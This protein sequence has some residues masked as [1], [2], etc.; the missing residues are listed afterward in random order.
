MIKHYGRREFLQQ[1][2]GFGACLLLASN[3]IYLY[4]CEDRK[5]QISIEAVNFIGDPKFKK[6]ILLGMDGLDPRVLNHLM[7]TGKLPNFFKLSQLGSYSPLA[8]SNPA[9]SPVAWASIATGNNPGYHGMFDFLNRRVTDHMP[10]LAI[11]KMNSDNFFGK[12]ESMFLPAMEGNSF[13][14][15]TS[16]N[17]VSSTILR[18][19]VTFQPKKN[20]AKLYAGLGVPDLNG[21]LGTYS[22]FTTT[23]VPDDAKGAEKV[24]RV[25]LR[26]NKIKT[27]I[28]GPNVSGIASGDQAKTELNV[29]LLKDKSAVKV[30]AGGKT[31]TVSRKKW[32]GWFEVNFKVGIL[33]TVS[34][35]VK[36][37]LNEVDPDFE[38]YMTPIQINPKDPAFVITNPDNYI[39]ELYGDLG[40]FYTLGIS[41]DTKALSEGRLDEEAF[42]AMCDEITNEQE[43]MLWNE[44]NKFKTG[45]YA[46]SFFST[47][48]IQHMF[49]ATRDNGHPLYTDA[50]A[51]KYGHVID[52]YYIRMDR[53][54]GELMKNLDSSTALIAFSDHGFS[55]LRRTVN[56]NTW[57]AEKGFMKLKRKMD[58]HDKEGGPLFEYVDWNQTYAYSLGFGSIYINLKGREKY[59]VV[60]PGTGARSVMDKISQ[61]LLALKDPKYGK[62]SV[63]NVYRSD[64]IYS[65]SNMDKSPDHCSGFWEWIQGIM[66]DSDRRSPLRC[67]S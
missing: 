13:W 44:L 50:Y 31:M 63:M 27:E 46:F 60:E 29:T 36:F 45:V 25:R 51:R 28:A 5:S 40:H 3:G 10:E 8:T 11:F 58:E 15:Y 49:W 12:R 53:I 66:A 64:T 41:E 4:G 56:I 35:I 20:E 22:Y 6:V 67:L 16:A 23:R 52:G 39:K 57:L 33:K 48:R 14:D 38:M 43:D 42:I 55:T 34:G 30:E 24:T 47:D 37:Y 7:A 19:P 9:Q 59:G 62:R 21:R 65:G 17:N 1:M 2:S 54:L 61:E 32:S 26:G 18:W